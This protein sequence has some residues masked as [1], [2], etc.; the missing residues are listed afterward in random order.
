MI[1]ESLKSL[2]CRV[3]QQFKDVMEFKAFTTLA[4]NYATSHAKSLPAKE[5]LTIKYATFAASI[6]LQDIKITSADLPP[7]Y[8]K[9][10][11]EFLLSL[12]HQQQ[13]AIFEQQ[14]FDVLELL[15][16]DQ[17]MRM[18][19][20]KQV[21]YSVITAAQ[22]REEILME[23]V[24][25]ELSELKYRSV[26][27]WFV[28]LEKLVS[29]CKVAQDKI[30]IIAEA[31]ATRDLIVHNGGKIDRT[32]LC[33]TG[34]RARGK[35]GDTVSVAGRYTLDTWQVLVSV[36]IAMVDILIAKF[37]EEQGGQAT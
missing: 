16:L 1:G 8:E 35:L 30:S 23:L 34:D 22:T 31:K 6:G 33:K 19:S 10:Q 18:S 13:L 36:L 7:Q 12:V 11:N 15:L 5:V 27:D 25:L 37:G 32:Y 9:A 21:A 20:R 24:N 17:P 3:I 2:R 26:S 14:L 4:Y 29:E 28:Y